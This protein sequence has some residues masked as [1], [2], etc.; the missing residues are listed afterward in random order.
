MTELPSNA[1]ARQCVVLIGFRGCGKSTVGRKLAQLLGG[2]FIDTDE[3]ISRETGKA[4]AALF[5]EEGEAA[6][7]R[8]ESEAITKAAAAAPAVISVGGG[9]VMN[10]TN[11]KLLRAAGK[12]VW[13][14]AP[15][16]VL[17]QRIIADSNTEDTRPALTPLSRREETERVL[18]ERLPFYRG[19][20]DVVVDT[21]SLD[22]KEVAE[23][24][25]HRLGLAARR[26]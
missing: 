8:R 19:A 10:P 1:R 24:I 4:I 25:M 7:R 11:T 17:H 15:A 14:T 20:A 12:V 18:A 23:E 16:E 2:R 9:A 21:S 5:E 22:P 6:F 26:S 13:L 3:L